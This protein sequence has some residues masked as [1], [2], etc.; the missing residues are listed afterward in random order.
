MTGT[1]RLAQ[2][3]RWRSCPLAEKTLWSLG[4]L[5][6]AVS[7]PPWPGG[8]LILTAA[9][10]SALAAGTPPLA[11]A[12]LGV[13]PG[14]FILTGAASIMVQIGADGVAMAPDGPRLAAELAVRSM[15][16]L[17]ALLLLAV[18]TPISH[19][20]HG[21]RRLGLPRELAE[22]A[23]VT[24]RFIFVLLDTATAMHVS[25]SSRLGHQGWRRRIRS[26]GLLC[27]A[28]LPRALDRAGR[29]DTGLAARGFQ[30]DLCTLVPARPPRPLRL[31][32]IGLG[33]GMIGGMTWMI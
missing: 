8:V 5:A 2:A 15:A 32:A 13:A 14:L 21:L 28:L 17:S 19:L 29:L 20:L 30:G 9:I 3:S 24:Y 11:L 22:V 26:L 4:L 7:L 12:G 16:S 18:T 31:L 6:L 27:A 1:D 25:Q 33:L 10:A 23:L